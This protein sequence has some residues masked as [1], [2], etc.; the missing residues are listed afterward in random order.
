[1]LEQRRSNSCSAPPSCAGEWSGGKAPCARMP[2]YLRKASGAHESCTSKHDSTHATGGVGLTAAQI[3]GSPCPPAA[4][5]PGWPRTACTR[6]RRASAVTP[7]PPSRH[8]PRTAG[9]NNTGSTAWQ[10]QYS[11]RSTAHTCCAPAVTP[12]RCVESALSRAQLQATERSGGR[13]GGCVRNPCRAQRCRASMTARTRRPGSGMAPE[14]RGSAKRN[15]SMRETAYG[16]VRASRSATT[17]WPFP[18]IA[19]R[20][21]GLSADSEI[22]A[23]ATDSAAVSAIPRPG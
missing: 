9:T 1:M 3:A 11:R 13:G 23:T 20:R 2:K 10:Q 14:N 17:P 18:S 5:Q 16:W 12:K 15:E 22:A 19:T 4:W 7:R 8:S 21:K 6:A